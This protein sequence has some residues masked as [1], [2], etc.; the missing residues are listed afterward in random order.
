MGEVGTSHGIAK[1]EEGDIGGFGW[2]QEFGNGK[3][4]IAGLVLSTVLLM[5]AAT[6]LG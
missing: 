6:P 1:G 5:T 3:M 4:D 2:L